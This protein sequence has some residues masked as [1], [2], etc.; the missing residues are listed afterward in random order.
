MLSQVF[1]TLLKLKADVIKD[2][3]QL[4]TVH[5]GPVPAPCHCRL[6]K[7]LRKNLMFFHKYI[8]F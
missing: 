2:M 4:D 5:T 8:L 7:G 3:F 6:E 1:V